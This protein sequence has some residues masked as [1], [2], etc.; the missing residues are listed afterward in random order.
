MDLSRY[1]KALRVVNQGRSGAG[2]NGAGR[3]AG[4]TLKGLEKPR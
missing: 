2:E 1:L 3:L 4:S